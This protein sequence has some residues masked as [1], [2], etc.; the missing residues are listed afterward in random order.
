[1][2]TTRSK[3]RK[4][5]RKHKE[6]KKK[7]VAVSNLRSKIFGVPILLQ[8]FAVALV[9]CSAKEGFWYILASVHKDRRRVLL[10]SCRS[11][12]LRFCIRVSLLKVCSSI[13]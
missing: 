11:Q 10:D 4:L 5:V 7:K 2:Q 13:L 3:D 9:F 1:M 12:G 6:E 8:G